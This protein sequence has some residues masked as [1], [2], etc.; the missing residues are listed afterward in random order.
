MEKTISSTKRMFLV[1]SCAPLMRRIRR[2]LKKKE[3]AFEKKKVNAI[4]KEKREKVI[5][6]E[7]EGN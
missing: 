2:E 5:E 4:K 7:R 1:P 6:K 3:K